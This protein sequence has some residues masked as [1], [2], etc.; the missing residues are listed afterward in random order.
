M[1]ALGAK[2]S[3]AQ[4]VT[5]ASDVKPEQV[6]AALRPFAAAA[7]E[8][9]DTL[10]KTELTVAEIKKI[11]A[12]A[13][14]AS[15]A[16][17]TSA[18]KMADSAEQMKGLD[19]AGKAVENQK[20][21]VDAADAEIKKICEAGAECSELAKVLVKFPTPPEKTDNL[22]A[23]GVWTGKLSAWAAELAKVKID[24]AN[25]KTQVTGFDQ[26]WKALAAAMSTLVTITETAKKFDEVA[27][28]FSTQID[29]ANKAISDANGYCKS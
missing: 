4:K 27:K 6:A 8:T 7:K 12:E 16:L 20:K 21:I 14:V 1:N 9:G 29:S 17:A 19:A 24:N 13:S 18:T 11:A 22:E 5:G 28:V 2:L 10:A 23:T 3:D 15:L 26:A 25:L